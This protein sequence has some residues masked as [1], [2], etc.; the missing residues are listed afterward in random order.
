MTEACGNKKCIRDFWLENLKER[1]HL[2]YLEVGDTIINF[3]FLSL[4]RR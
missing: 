4:F 2:A 1:E 3:K